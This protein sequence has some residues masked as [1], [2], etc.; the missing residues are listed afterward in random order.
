MHPQQTSRTM[1]NAVCKYRASKT[2][3]I[4]PRVDFL[5]WIPQALL[6]P[7][8]ATRVKAFIYRRSFGFVF[9]PSAVL[10]LHTKQRC[11]SLPT[12][13]ICA[14]ISPETSSVAQHR[15]RDVIL[16]SP[17][18]SMRIPG[19]ITTLISIICPLTL[20]RR[21]TGNKTRSKWWL[22]VNHCTYITTSSHLSCN[23]HTAT[24]ISN[25]RI[26][27]LKF[28]DAHTQYLTYIPLSLFLWIAK[29]IHLMADFKCRIHTE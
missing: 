12:I 23:I 27:Q 3:H 17:W 26:P 18:H 20:S 25:E 22:S 16:S 1:K 4:T 5:A 8:F 21:Q 24:T 19:P 10:K 14:Q 11:L 29:V 28:S 7:T 9:F 2:I 13:E 15:R 6:P